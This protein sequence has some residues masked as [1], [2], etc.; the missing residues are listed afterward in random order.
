MDALTWLS[1]VAAGVK[2]VSVVKQLF[3]NL[4]KPVIQVIAWAVTIGL[5]FLGAEMVGIKDTEFLAGH[6][7]GSLDAVTK[8]GLGFVLGS[9]GSLAVDTI[10]ARDQ[11]KTTSV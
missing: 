6:T 2:I 5:V 1:L 8:F 9:T 10:T 4:S 3:P 11:S 7:L